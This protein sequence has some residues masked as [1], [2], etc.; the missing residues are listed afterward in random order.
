MLHAL[1]IGRAAGLIDPDK[2]LALVALFVDRN[3]ILG[4]GRFGGSEING[5]QDP[6]MNGKQLRRE[7][8]LG[9]F[10]ARNHQHLRHV[11][12]VQD[13]VSR[14]ISGDLT[15]AGLERWLAARAA[16]AGFRVA[17][18]ACRAIDDARFGQRL[19]R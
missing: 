11:P 9:F 6:A 15:K 8:Q 17:H 3:Q 1:E 2:W 13:G 19:Q 18:N 14:K 10:Q 4:R 7:T 5:F 16:H 12:V